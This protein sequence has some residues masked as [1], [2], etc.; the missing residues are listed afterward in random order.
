[1][2][3]PAGQNVF[4]TIEIELCVTELLIACFIVKV[5]FNTFHGSSYFVNNYQ[6]CDILMLPVLLCP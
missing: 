6:F 1:M 2:M 5:K 3:N 4:N